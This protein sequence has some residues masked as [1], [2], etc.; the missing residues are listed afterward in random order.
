MAPPYPDIMADHNSFNNH[1]SR[2]NVSVFQ[3][4]YPLSIR[5]WSENWRG[6]ELTCRIDFSVTVGSLQH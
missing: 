2:N 5:R 1:P 6:E 3:C 4:N